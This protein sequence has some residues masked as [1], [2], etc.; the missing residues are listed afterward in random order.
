M[1]ILCN[2]IFVHIM[3]YQ[4][5]NQVKASDM[6]HVKKLYKLAENLLSCRAAIQVTQDINMA[7]SVENFLHSFNTKLYVI[8]IVIYHD[9]VAA[10]P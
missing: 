8:P 5:L 3:Q 4:S 2:Q 1:N 10:A 9:Y 6:L 7:A